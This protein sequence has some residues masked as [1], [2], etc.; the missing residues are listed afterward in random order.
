MGGDALKGP[1]E[2][3]LELNK[4]NDGRAM[5][6]SGRGNQLELASVDSSISGS[7]TSKGPAAGLPGGIP[8]P[9]TG[10]QQPLPPLS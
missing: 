6:N 2:A 7:P 10:K 5:L 8:S 3:N 1:S 4:A 9:L